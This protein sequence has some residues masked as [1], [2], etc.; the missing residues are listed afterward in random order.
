MTIAVVVVTVVL[1]GMAVWVGV[2]AARLGRRV[3]ASRPAVEAVG[4]RLRAAAAELEEEQAILRVESDTVRLAVTRLTT[5]RSPP[6]R[7]PRPW[8]A[9]RVPVD[10]ADPSPTHAAGPPAKGD[11]GMAGG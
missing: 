10:G 4:D 8:A 6:N 1:I 5:R 9:G 11:A 2:L 7:W 3:R